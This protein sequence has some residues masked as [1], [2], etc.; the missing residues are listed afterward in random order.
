MK[1]ISIFLI[2]SIITLAISKFVL[3]N[4]SI[5]MFIINLKKEGFFD[6]IQSINEL[7]G[8]DVA[9][10]S[11]EEL[12]KKRC[13]NCKRVVTDY[14]SKPDKTV[15]KDINSKDS[16]FIHKI[17]SKKFSSEKTQLIYQRIIEKA[18]KLKN[19]K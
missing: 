6:I 8:Q 18:K 10:I 5:N 3:D 4:Y 15:I 2:L 19:S 17:L 12:N 14:M 7:Y 11:C 9:I 13:G 1:S 16:I